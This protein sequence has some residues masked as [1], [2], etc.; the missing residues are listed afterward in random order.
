MYNQIL[1]P[2]TLGDAPDAKF[3][4][5]VRNGATSAADQPTCEAVGAITLSPA[6]SWGD[7]HHESEA[8]S[9]IANC[10][11]QEGAWCKTCSSGFVPFYDHE[12]EPDISGLVSQVADLATA[13]AAT[14]AE[15]V[16]LRSEVNS[17]NCFIGHMTDYQYW[18]SIVETEVVGEG[19]YIYTDGSYWGEQTTGYQD[20]SGEPLYSADIQWNQGPN[21]DSTKAY[22]DCF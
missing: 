19:E 15:V 6:E 17:L 3:F 5:I 20:P 7:E 22:E 12:D 16:A 8:G 13:L 21:S 2:F 10:A 9:D 4:F 11:S 14:E 18:N 1:Q